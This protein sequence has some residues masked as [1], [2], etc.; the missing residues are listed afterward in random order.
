MEIYEVLKLVKRWIIVAKN[1]FPKI[2]G[3]SLVAFLEYKPENERNEEEIKFFNTC[4]EPLQFSVLTIMRELAIQ[5]TELCCYI[6]GIQILVEAI[7]NPNYKEISEEIILTLLFLANNPEKRSL[8]QTYLD[9]GKI[10][11]LFTDID[12]MNTIYIEKQMPNKQFNYMKNQQSKYEEQL[13][14]A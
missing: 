4:I 9:F 5:N 10:F 11:A 12:Y 2:L 6:G 7:I 1:S 14:L 13:T 3:S 8:I